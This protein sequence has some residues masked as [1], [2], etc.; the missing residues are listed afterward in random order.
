MPLARTYSRSCKWQ[1]VQKASAK[2]CTNVHIAINADSRLPSPSAEALIIRS[3]GEFECSRPKTAHCIYHIALPHLDRVFNRLAK[4]SEPR[5]TL[6]Q[7]RC[8]ARNRSSV[9]ASDRWWE[10]HRYGAVRL[11]STLDSPLERKKF[12]W[13]SETYQPPQPTGGTGGLATR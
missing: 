11:S 2:V 10:L 4:T 5:M 3:L 12:E 1:N 8:H 9:A 13:K 6:C 7:H